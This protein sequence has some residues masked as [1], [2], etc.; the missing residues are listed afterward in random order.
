MGNHFSQLSE[1][2]IDNFVLAAR[3]GGRQL[4]NLTGAQRSEI[5]TTLGDL[6]IKRKDDIMLAN[7]RDLENAEKENLGTAER[8]RLKMTD[9][10]IASLAYG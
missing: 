8:D 3:E 4:A 1:Q 6:L 10:K 2:T 7:S 5:I 9:A